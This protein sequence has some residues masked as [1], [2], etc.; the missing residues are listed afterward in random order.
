MGAKG[1]PSVGVLLN[2]VNMN[3]ELPRRQARGVYEGVPTLDR[4]VGKPD[5]NVYSTVLW[6]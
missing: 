2:I 5:L 4:E 1:E 3:V 6:A